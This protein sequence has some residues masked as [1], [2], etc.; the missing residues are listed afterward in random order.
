MKETKMTIVLVAI[1]ILASLGTVF[2]MLLAQETHTPISP[3]DYIPE[4]NIKIDG[5]KLEIT[6]TLDRPF[7]M[8]GV[9]ATGSMLPFANEYT[10]VVGFKPL[11]SREIDNGD[12]IVYDDGKKF[13][14]HRVIDRIFSGNETY[15]KTKG[16]NNL[17]SDSDLVNIN[18]I[19][20]K[21]VMVVY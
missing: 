11:Y 17:I 8:F 21:V 4:R 1:T 3:G 13:V 18:D 15:F 14:M 5:S 10:N 9:E 2:A 6:N 12:I 7:D 19:A 16:D 20:M